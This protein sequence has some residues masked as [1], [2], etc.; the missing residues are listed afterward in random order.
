MYVAICMSLTVRNTIEKYPPTLIFI[1]YN[2]KYLQISCSQMN[3]YETMMQCL[4]LICIKQKL[5]DLKV[6]ADT[7]N[8][9]QKHFPPNFLFSLAQTP[10]FSEHPASSRNIFMIKSNQ[11]NNYQSHCRWLLVLIALSMSHYQWL[12]V[13]NLFRLNKTA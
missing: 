13:R 2:C 5:K 9:R 3:R 7:V 8:V 10:R 11:V 12:M 4:P 1:T 6:I